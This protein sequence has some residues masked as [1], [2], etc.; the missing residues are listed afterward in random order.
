MTNIATFGLRSS[1]A[2]LLV[3]LT[4]CRIQL[5]SATS[6]APLLPA[7][8]GAASP[9]LDPQT[10]TPTAPTGT[11]VPRAPAPPVESREDEGPAGGSGPAELPH[12]TL[13]IH[14]NAPD[15]SMQVNHRIAVTNGSG[16]PWREVVLSVPP[17]HWP[18]TFDLHQAE[19]AAPTWRQV[20]VTELDNTM[21]HVRL[22]VELA[23]GQALTLTLDYA[24]RIPDITPETWLPEGNLGAGERLIQ[25]G[26]WH[27]TL[28][29]YQEGSG[30]QTWSYHPVGDPTVYPL[31]DYD[32]QITAD[33]D[34]VIAAPGA[35]EEEGRRRRYTLRR[36][37]SFAFLASAEYRLIEGQAEGI[38]IRV[39]Y[40]PDHVEGAY[41]TVDTARKALSL[42]TEYYGAYPW[43]GLVIAQNAYYGAMEYAGLVS[44]SGAVLAG[45]NGSPLSS[46]VHLTAHEIAH[47]W[48][49]GAVGN[50]QVHEP[51]LDESLAKYSEFLFYERYHPDRVDAWWHKQVHRGDAGGPLDRTIYD[52]TSTSAY[53]GDLY[54]QG[55]RFM[56]DLRAL[57]GDDAFFDFVAAYRR[58]GDGKLVTGE[59]FFNVLGAYATPE[60][61]DPLVR[62]YFS[63]AFPLPTE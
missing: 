15:R 57:L 9:T 30:W 50:D 35:A 53:I 44:M 24:V 48:W 11:P 54:R 17:A 12:H 32:V 28:V 40:L 46:L 60:E 29:P 25:A 62:R 2:L 13:D 19:V 31:A 47:Q 6:P 3:L 8:T 51:W 10:D 43:A 20:A 18:R 41:A 36:A 61:L 49:Y 22:P 58:Y 55:A 26:D 37:R 38:P 42:F 16:E 14:L 21:L 39:Y 63:A 1:L 23:A 4:G 45:Y 56:E 7:T 33:A 52:F 5:R 27:P 59:D 34:L